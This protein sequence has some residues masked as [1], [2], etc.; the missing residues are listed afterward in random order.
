MQHV[1]LLCVRVYASPA[2]AEWLLT[3]T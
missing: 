2:L 3:T 1:V